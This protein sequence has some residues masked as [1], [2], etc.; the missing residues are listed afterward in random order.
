MKLTALANVSRPKA[1]IQVKHAIM[2]STDEFTLLQAQKMAD[3]YIF[4]ICPKTQREDHKRDL[5]Y[6]INFRKNQITEK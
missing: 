3:R 2:Q 5:D 1:F 4:D 6:I